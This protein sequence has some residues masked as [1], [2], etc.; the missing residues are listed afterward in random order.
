MPTQNV[1]LTDT[2]DIFVKTQVSLG[3]Y[4]D[5][6]EVHRAALAAL[7]RQEEERQLRM[8]QLRH[9]IQLGINELEVGRSV[10]IGSTEEL[11]SMLDGCLERTIQRLERA[12]AEPVA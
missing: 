3:H 12:N 8:G 5:A 1:N 10:K 11:S 4:N 7:V 2:L 6:S 9:E